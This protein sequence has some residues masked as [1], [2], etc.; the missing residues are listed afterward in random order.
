[1]SG[2][3]LSLDIARLRVA[4]DETG[5]MRVPAG[6]RELLNITRTGYYRWQFNIRHILYDAKHR[7]TI[8]EY[9]YGKYY[10]LFRQKP[11]QLCGVETASIPLLLSIQTKFWQ[12]GLDINAFTIRKNS[13]QYGRMNIIEGRPLGVPAMFVDD[14][15][16]QE[17]LTFWHALGIMGNYGIT[18]YHTLFAVVYKMDDGADRLIQT[19]RGNVMIDSLFKKSDFTL[20]PP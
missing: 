2:S 13:K 17:H 10:N 20:D 11:F 8:A 1:M 16:S 15:I 14:L 4:I 3:Q 12:C 9:F 19:S 5:I 6:S 18:P 7:N